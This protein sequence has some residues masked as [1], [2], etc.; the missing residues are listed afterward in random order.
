MVYLKYLIVRTQNNTAL[1]PLFLY[2][3]KGLLILLIIQNN[4]FNNFEKKK[5]NPVMHCFWT[6]T[7]CVDFQF[8]VAHFNTGLFQHNSVQTCVTFSE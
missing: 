1:D 5:K 3:W 8:A 7:E 4:L 2:S 6:R